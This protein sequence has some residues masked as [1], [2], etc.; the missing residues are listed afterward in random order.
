[1]SLQHPAV[2]QPQ[3]HEAFHVA[4]SNRF[5]P[6]PRLKSASIEEHYR[7][8]CVA[9][10]RVAREVPGPQLRRHQGCR[11]FSKGTRSL[12]TAKRVTAVDTVVAPHIC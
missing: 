11:V 12:I 7:L 9:F 2:T 10:C 8:G 4:M 6:L 3:Q 1:M 5:G